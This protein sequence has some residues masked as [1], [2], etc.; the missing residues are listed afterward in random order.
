[1]NNVLSETAIFYYSF[2]S[3]Q[4]CNATK[5]NSH[6]TEKPHQAFK[7]SGDPA[8]EALLIEKGP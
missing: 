4:I 5:K 3:K 1:M 8:K 6:G 2:G 7:F